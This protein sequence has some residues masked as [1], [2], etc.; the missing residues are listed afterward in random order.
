MLFRS[1]Y[2]IDVCGR[3]QAYCVFFSLEF[4]PE[5]AAHFVLSR[6][7]IHRPSTVQL[8]VAVHRPT[9]LESNQHGFGHTGH[10]NNGLA[11]DEVF[12]TDE[13]GIRK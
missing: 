9:V 3:P 10:I 13:G 12:S 6:F 4:R 2:Q 5:G 7:E 1:W 11:L 8:I